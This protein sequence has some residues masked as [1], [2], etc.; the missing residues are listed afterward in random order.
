MHRNSVKPRSSMALALCSTAMVL[1]LAGCGERR[2]L[3]PSLTLPGPAATIPALAPAP[4]KPARITQAVGAG[5]AGRFVRFGERRRAEP[6]PATLLD[7]GDQVTMNLSGVSILEMAEKVLGDLVGAA[8]VIEE[9]LPGVADLR[10]SGPRTK[11]EIV[12]MFEEV[13]ASR[14][15][16]LLWSGGRF[17]I[18][19]LDPASPALRAPPLQR[20]GL[21]AG[22]G[23]ATRI[24]P[25]DHIAPSKLAELLSPIAP[26][27]AVRSAD[28]GSGVIALTGS[29]GDLDEIEAMIDVFDVDWLTGKSIAFLPLSRAD[30]A[31]IAD[32]LLLMIEPEQAA[33][34]EGTRIVP[35][36]QAR[37]VLVVS[38]NA[39]L[40]RTVEDILPYLDTVV[41][42]GRA[43]YVYEVQNRSAA[44]LA[45]LVGRV[46]EQ[47]GG[48]APPPAA[49]GA[50]EAQPAV[51]S[52]QG[53][54]P[55]SGGDLSVIAD[56]AGNAL[57]IRARPEI[58]QQ[59]LAVVQRLDAA[60]HQVL[61]E[62]TIAEITLSDQLRYGLEYYLRFGDFQGSFTGNP[63]GAVAPAAPGLSLL[64]SGTNASVV[65]NALSAVTD[66]NVVSSPSLMVVDNREAT[67]RVGD[68]VPIVLQSAVSVS[69]PDAPIVNSIAY[70]DTGVTMT[71]TPR[72]SDNGLVLLEIEQDVSDVAPTTT[73]GIDSPTIRQRRIATTV[74]V[75][76]GESLALGGLMR[77]QE[78][79]EVNGVP[80][81]ADAPVIGDLFKTTDDQRQRTELLVLITPRVVRN[82]SDSRRVT[83]ELRQRM[84][85]LDPARRTAAQ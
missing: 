84:G 5:K 7:G 16:A 51:F 71:V 36:Q 72:V 44:E 73:S 68:Q 74:S 30:P 9:D 46:F 55:S 37:A 21:A 22:V 56:D 23:Y 59:A 50:P 69:D 38:E 25:V 62:V 29:Q 80:I 57:I 10:T 34:A 24:V 70:R 67:L 3:G 64:L 17:R 6:P 85:S 27:G 40:V 49:Q 1:S 79:T 82:R 4:A 14:G 39:E 19:A 81:L 2:D 65:L 43:V 77:T 11:R 28:D 31:A 18:V 76:D 60:P 33:G 83:Q 15:G 8:Y 41:G 48:S 26:A 52:P 12:R 35:V 63:L 47:G 42:D 45:D 78:G 61:L 75:S 20:S 13:L 54:A 32:E 53:G 66:V 58:Y